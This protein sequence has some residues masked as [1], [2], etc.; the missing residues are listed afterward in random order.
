[1][2]KSKQMREYFDEKRESEENITIAEIAENQ[3]VRY[4]FAYQVIR[5]YC[6]KNNYEMPTNNTGDS[7]ADTIRQLFDDGLTI[8]EIA[9]QLNTNYSYCWQVCDEHRKDQ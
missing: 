4:A 9:K 1:M 5:R 8:G 7:K 3:D 2:N 6:D